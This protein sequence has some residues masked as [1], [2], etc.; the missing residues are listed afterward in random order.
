M[1]FRVSGWGL[2]VDGDH[3]CFINACT[4]A[5]CSVAGQSRHMS[6]RERKKLA[7]HFRKTKRAYILTL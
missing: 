6:Q 7:C 5:W 3:D 4:R 1:K 2:Q